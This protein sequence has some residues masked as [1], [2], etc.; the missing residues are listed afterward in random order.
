MRILLTGATGHVGGRL[1]DR[2]VAEGH[3]VRALSR[4]PERL[5]ERPGVEPFRGDV[6]DRASLDGAFAGI[7]AAYYLV[8]S[9]DETGSFEETE[10]RAAETFAAAAADAGVRRIVYLGGLAHGRDLSPHLRSR[11]EVGSALRSGPVPVIEF[12]ASVVLGSGSASYELIRT[13][14]DRLPAL[15]APSWLETRTQP[16]ALA[17]VVDYLAAALDLELDGS[18]I[19]EIGGADALTYRELIGQY[20]SLRG[21]QMPIV[22]LPAVPL[23][24]GRIVDALP[25]QLAPERTRVAAKLVEGLR[26]DST[27]ADDSATRD[28]PIRP[29]SVRDA[30]EEAMSEAA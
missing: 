24:L 18:R 12:R 15:A 16:I 10:K 28:F 30:L 7:E 26:F 22:E 8:H 9:L 13:L 19:Y 5:G 1:L 6:G 20:A 4:R 14:V 23:P 27:V 3:E 21:L 2:L 11:L 29:R 17:D 25:K